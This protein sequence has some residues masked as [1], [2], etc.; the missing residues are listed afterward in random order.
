MM[1]VR[2]YTNTISVRNEQSITRLPTRKSQ[3]PNIVRYP[4]E[5]SGKTPHGSCRLYS[6]FERS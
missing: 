5:K 3:E 6:F 4:S 1:E 2:S